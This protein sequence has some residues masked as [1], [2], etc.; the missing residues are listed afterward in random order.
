MANIF[1]KGKCLSYK[2]QVTKGQ[3]TLKMKTGKKTT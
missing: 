1:K 2:M 3:T